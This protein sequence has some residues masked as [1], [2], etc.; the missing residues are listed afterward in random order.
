MDGFEENSGIVVMA[1]TNA[2]EILDPAL[3]R[4]GRF[5]RSVSVPLPDVHGRREILDL[6]LKNK[7][8]AAGVDSGLIARRTPGFSGAE[9]ASLVNEAALAC[10]RAGASVIDEAALD[11]ARDKLI[12]GIPRALQQVRRA[13]GQGWEGGGRAAT[14]VGGRAR[15]L[16][17]ER[18]A[19]EQRLHGRSER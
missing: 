14:R 19:V 15:G 5:D 11:E 18:R 7:P 1:A 13:R 2:P 6:Y 4:P 9:L 3:T 8:L 17:R 16:A 12:M 10:A